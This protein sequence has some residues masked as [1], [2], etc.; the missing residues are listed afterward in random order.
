MSDTSDQLVS[1][2]INSLEANPLQPRGTITP[3]S[4]IDLIDSIKEHGI[5]EPLIIAHTPAGYQIIAGERRWRAAKLAGL[6]V[7]PAIVKKTTP[8]GMLEMAIVENLQREDLNPIDRAR[9]FQRL[10]GEFGYTQADIAKKISKSV[11]YVSNTMK[12]LRL[13]DALTDGLLSGAI[14]EGHARALSGIDDPHAMIAAYKKILSQSG[15]VRMAE[16]L[17]RQYRTSLLKQGETKIPVK[18][19]QLVL[20]G[21]L[22]AMEEELR[23]VMGKFS[24]VNLKQTSREAKIMIMFKGSPNQTDAKVKAIYKALKEIELKENF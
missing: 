17:S 13:P 11:P 15:S 24:K 18:P 8:K 2:D 20:S 23:Q 7:V 4:L 5:L 22:E 16:E 14:T 19:S 21:Q 12:M 1:L 10:I 9:A 6:S 3:D